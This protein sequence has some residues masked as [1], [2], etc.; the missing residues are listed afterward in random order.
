MCET[1]HDDHRDSDIPASRNDAPKPGLVNTRSGFLNGARMGLVW[2]LLKTHRQ[3]LEVKALRGECREA[4]AKREQVS[5]FW[6]RLFRP[7]RYENAQAHYD[8]VTTRLFQA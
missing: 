4:H 7:Q 3:R 5:G 8:Q 1:G 2:R 6:G